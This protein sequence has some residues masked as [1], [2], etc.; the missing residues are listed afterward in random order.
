M[1]HLSPPPPRPTRSATLYRP[2]GIVRRQLRLAKSS[3]RRGQQGGC[4]SALRVLVG[5]PRTGVHIESSIRPI[6]MRSTI[7]LESMTAYPARAPVIDVQIPC[8]TIR[9]EPQINLQIFPTPWRSVPPRPAC[10]PVSRLATLPI[11]VRLPSGTSASPAA[12]PVTVVAGSRQRSADRRVPPAAQDRPDALAR[13]H[14]R[15]AR[16]LER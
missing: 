7:R 8:S 12:R 15:A 5:D 1:R 16:R 11:D 14:R 2:V 10:R 13:P 4:A 9:R 3:A 6:R